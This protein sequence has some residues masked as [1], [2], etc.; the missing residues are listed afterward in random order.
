MRFD[1]RWMITKIYPETPAAFKMLFAI[2]ST[3]L[4]KNCILD[5]GMSLEYT[6]CICYP[7]FRRPTGFWEITRN[8]EKPEQSPQNIY[9]KEFI[10]KNIAGL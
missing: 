5:L 7:N 3:I 6:F 8:I 2:I 1:Q 10:F 9:V 4:T